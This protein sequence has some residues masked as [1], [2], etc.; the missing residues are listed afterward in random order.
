MR[1]E[2]PSIRQASGL[3]RKW[4]LLG[5]EQVFKD[6]SM[7]PSSGRKKVLV[8]SMH[9]YAQLNVTPAEDILL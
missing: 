2:P 6:G 8:E 4:T 5:A 7:S 1:I 3:G 9:R